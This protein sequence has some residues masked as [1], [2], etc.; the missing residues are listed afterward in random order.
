M[1][2]HSATLL[3]NSISYARVSCRY[4]SQ[5]VRQEI[6]VPNMYSLIVLHLDRHLLRH[7]L[8]NLMH[9]L[10]VLSLRHVFSLRGDKTCRKVHSLHVL[11]LLRQ[12][13]YNLSFPSLVVCVCVCVCVCARAHA[14][15]RVCVCV[16]PRAR[17]CMC[18]EC[19]WKCICP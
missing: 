5:Y 2:A 10:H 14:R 19:V 13:H 7:V 11:S 8:S 15:A 17:V 12:Q 3:S 4:T 16:C 1:V 9:C 18:G 6:R